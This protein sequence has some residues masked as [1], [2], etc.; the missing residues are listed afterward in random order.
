MNGLTRPTPP[1]QTKE[2]PFEM[3]NQILLRLS[4]L[5]PFIALLATACGGGS[6]STPTPTGGAKPIDPSGNWTMTATDGGGK[7][8]AFAALFAQI[9]ADVSANSFTA[10]GNPAP[11]SCTPFTA[12]LSNGLVQNVSTFTGTVT[13][14]N[15]FGAFTFTAT[16]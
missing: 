11:F 2:R 13:F 7:T 9:G 8:I 5:L 14:G 10:A 4:R 16:L 15:N 12:A 1:N 3:A 6:S